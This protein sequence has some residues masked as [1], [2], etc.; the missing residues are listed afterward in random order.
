M[1][2]FSR[3][4]K[5]D[6]VIGKFE[7]DSKQFRLAGGKEFAILFYIG[8]ETDGVKICDRMFEGS[9]IKEPPVFPDS[10]VSKVDALKN[11]YYMRGY[12]GPFP[13]EE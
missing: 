13:D 4:K 12:E 3:M 8:M 9:W 7:Y 11:C 6:G 5:Y 2:L 1:G 10:V